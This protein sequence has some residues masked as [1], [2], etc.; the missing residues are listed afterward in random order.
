MWTPEVNVMPSAAV[1]SISPIA[2][3]NP[4]PAKLTVSVDPLV[5]PAFIV[6]EAPPASFL[7]LFS[8]VIAPPFELIVKLAPL[9]R[10]SADSSNLS[11]SPLTLIVVSA[12]EI[13]VFRPS[14]AVIVV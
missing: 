8:A 3:P 13:L 7:I 1:I 6:R 4:I 12:C 10:D 9:E 11:A 2:S 5:V 14:L